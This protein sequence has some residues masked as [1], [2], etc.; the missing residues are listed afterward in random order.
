MHTIQI[1]DGRKHEVDGLCCKDRA[2]QS[3]LTSSQSIRQLQRADGLISQTLLY[4]A[5][6]AAPKNM[7][8]VQVTRKDTAAE[9]IS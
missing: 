9:L 8:V 2:L 5:T 7:I 1:S 4:V 3:V 6:I